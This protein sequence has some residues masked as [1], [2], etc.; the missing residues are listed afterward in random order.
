MKYFA[1]VLEWRGQAVLRLAR[2]RAIAPHLVL[3]A[4]G[5]SVASRSPFMAADTD[6]IAYWG[7]GLGAPIAGGWQLRVDLR[8]GVMPARTGGVTSTVELELGVGTTFGAA[9]AR[10]P[11]LPSPAAAAPPPVPGI[12][13]ADAADRDGDG[14]G[15]PDRLDACPDQPGTPSAP[16][17]AGCP[18]PEPEPDPDGDG[19]VGPADRCPDQP[20]DRDGWQDEDGCPD[21]D[22]DGDGIADAQDACPD[23]PE[24]V[25]G[26]QDEDGCPDELPGELTA[27]LAT[28]VRF[29]PGHARVTP[30]AG[31]ALRGLRE[32]LEH[33]PE[34]RI[35]IIGRPERRGGD[36]LA[37]RRS[38]AVKWHLVD[39]GIAEDRIVTR[40]VAAAPA[41]AR[42]PVLVFELLP[43]GPVA[44]APP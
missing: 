36:D 3:G 25:N 16:A 20:E 15:V 4:G 31:A 19:I 41:P 17:G 5:D 10:R 32:A 33:H 11:G 14:D 42:A 34:L 43:A 12:A 6:P 26:W 13:A 18:E 29:E 8:H 9:T 40:V 23:A 27:A 21:P 39:D 7:P 28:T 38:E 35:A 24:T 30:A 2:W 44:A 22:N 37:R 1:P